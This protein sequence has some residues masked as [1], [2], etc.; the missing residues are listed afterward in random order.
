MNC[1]SL[2][3]IELKLKHA[4]LHKKRIIDLLMGQLTVRLVL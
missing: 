4:Y 1:D 3:A 2:L